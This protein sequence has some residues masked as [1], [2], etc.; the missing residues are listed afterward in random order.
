MRL[1]TESVLTGRLFL[2]SFVKRIQNQV[3]DDVMRGTKWS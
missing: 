2:V 3:Q 1:R